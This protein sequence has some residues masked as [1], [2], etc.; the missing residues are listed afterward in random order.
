[1]TLE[2]LPVN[3]CELGEGPLW[4]PKLQS[5]F[6][7]DINAFKM[8]NWHN[9][10]IKTW[11]FAEP[12]SAAG[13]LDDD[14]ILIASASALI[15]FDL[16]SGDMETVKDLEA[17]IPG[18]RSNDGRADPWGGFWI[19]T[20]GLNAEPKA[21]SIYRFYEGELRQL[22][23]NITIPNSI[24]FSPDQS[25]GYFADTAQKM[26]WKQPL[27]RQTGWPTKDATV[28]VNLGSQ[29]LYPDGSVCD[30]EGYL[31]NAQ[32]GASRIARYN[33]NGI[34]E[35]V[36]NLPVTQIT[37]PAFGGENFNTIY[38]TTAFDGLN[39]AELQDQ[40]LAGRIF[41]F[42]S[43]IIGLAEYQVKL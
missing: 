2:Y 8:H 18:T 11:Q 39:S 28:F 17:D 25:Y 31:W 40:P 7:F 10:K 19:G 21:G 27:D 4:H 16:N 26:I 37:C 20:M 32:F 36:M 23:Q 22:H 24:C 34:L 14:S 5:L 41:Y 38:T 6:W 43:E 29:N 13:W 3:P 33:P 30:S 42:E 9:G 15:K 1:M 35:R 12:I